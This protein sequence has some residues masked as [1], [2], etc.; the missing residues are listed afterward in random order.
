MS[1]V[2]VATPGPP[3]LHQ[4]LEHPHRAALAALQDPSAHSLVAVTW[5][6]THLA[7]VARVLHPAARRVLPHGRARLRVV[8]EADRQLQ[9]A[10]WRLDRRL[11]GDVH[12][13]GR[14]VAELED[15]VARAL[16]AHARRESALV[17]ELTGHLSQDEQA[18]LGVRLAQ[19]VR[20][21]PTRPHPDA[22]VSGPAAALA[23]RVEAGADHLRDLF[24][25]RPQ[26]SPHDV[27]AP[28]VPGRWGSY[29]LGAPF[30]PPQTEA[31]R[32]G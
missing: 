31:T 29:L 11:T 1:T 25:N 7:A 8:M 32:S 27:L 6:A 22:P 4:A 18:G 23:F 30:P 13:S 19:A 28:V 3:S 2:P 20:R 16:L 12:V 15:D 10:L 24:D 14:V 17:D 26:P 9:R 5:C 21:A